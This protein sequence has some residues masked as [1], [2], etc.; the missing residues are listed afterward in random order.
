MTIAVELVDVHAQTL[1]AVKG[2]VAMGDIPD[3]IMPMMDKV[4][5]HI[6]EQGIEG[7]G[8]N[9]WLYRNVADGEMDV[10]IGVQLSAP[11]TPSGDVVAVQTPAGRE[12]GRAHV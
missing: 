3:K 7:H 2:H 4:W 12:I 9:V 6:R 1:V 10:E 8:H 5:A 11:F